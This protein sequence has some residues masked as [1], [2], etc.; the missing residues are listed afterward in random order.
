[1]SGKN[2]CIRTAIGTLSARGYGK[3][4]SAQI[5]RLREVLRRR[6]AQ[7][8]AAGQGDKANQAAQAS[9]WLA[10]TGS[11]ETPM[12]MAKLSKREVSYDELAEMI[13]NGTAQVIDVREPKELEENGS[14]PTSFNIP[15]MDLTA[16][17]QLTD[18]EFLDKYGFQKPG[19]YNNIVL[20]GRGEIKSATALEIAV[21]RG[22]KF[23]KR[24]PGGF[25]EWNQ[26]KKVKNDEESQQPKVED[27]LLT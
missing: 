11:L 25:E 14:I 22:L 18:I 20:Y 21:K 5:E 15:C 23:A 3:L 24:Y 27:L 4:S 13:E 26:K 10:M 12:P 9:R 7:S 1:M 19:I 17:L 16:A 8:A 6:S 2:F